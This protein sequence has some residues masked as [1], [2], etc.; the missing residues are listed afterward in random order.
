MNI[1]SEL[2]ISIVIVIL[3]FLLINPFEFLMPSM[4]EMAIVAC[5]AVLFFIFTIFVWNE[6][7]R[8]ERESFNRMR[9]DRV[10]FLA[11]SLI[12]IIGIIVQSIGHDLD[13]WL[14]ISLAVAVIAKAGSLIYGRI[15]N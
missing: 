6:K 9:A 13:H 10:A 4:I 7:A 14:L 12:L 11:G 3:L 8:D 5:L 2:A 15:K 1:I